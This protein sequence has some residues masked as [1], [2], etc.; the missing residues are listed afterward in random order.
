MI[1]SILRSGYSAA[2]AMKGEAT[3]IAAA[4]VPV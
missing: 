3:V 2:L 1:T 4:A